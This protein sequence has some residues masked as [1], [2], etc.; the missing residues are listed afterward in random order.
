MHQ[1]DPPYCHNDLKPGNVLLEKK[2]GKFSAVLMDFGSTLPAQRKV[3]TRREAL[4]IQVLLSFL[5]LSL[6]L[7]WLYCPLFNPLNS[8][9]FHFPINTGMGFPTL[10]C[11]F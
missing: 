9:K 1:S 5:Y 7:D 3:T 4:E 11:S 6:S 2:G 8:L 10:Q